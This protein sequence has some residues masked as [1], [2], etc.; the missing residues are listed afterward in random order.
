[1]TT[2]NLRNGLRLL[3]IGA[4]LVGVFTAALL[5]H[6]FGTTFA[7]RLVYVFIGVIFAAAGGLLLP[8]AVALW[9]QERAA[10]AGAVFMFWLLAILPLGLSGHAGFFSVA[11]SELV[12]QSIPAQAERARLERIDAGLSAS[13][14]YASADLSTLSAAADSAKAAVDA[15]RQTLAACPANYKTKCI[16]PARQQLDAAEENYR[17][18]Q[19]ELRNAKQYHGLLSERESALSSLASA[20]SGV[21][22][23]SGV[24]PLFDLFASLFDVSPATARA[25]FLSWSAVALEL[26]AAFAFIIAGS[27]GRSDHL[28]IPPAQ[29][30]PAYRFGG[31]VDHHGVAEL[32][33]TPDAPEYVLSPEMTQAVGGPDVLE[34]LRRKVHI[35]AMPSNSPS[36]DRPSSNGTP[37][38]RRKGVTAPC[39]DCGQPIVLKHRNHLRCD[40]CRTEHER[41]YR[42]K[43]SR[44]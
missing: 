42:V 10:P 37:S 18:A 3:G 21:G 26:V 5:Y 41:V 44:K 32:H 8:S 36:L 19:A 15:A 29:T 34:A 38:D 23:A 40:A 33:G 12:A 16:N 24:H 43:H 22:A 28:S 2:F 6:S 35:E 25:V 13:T 7:E 27:L 39:V 4:L 9:K 14:Q 1:M 31:I 30:V 20:S 11:Q 17:A